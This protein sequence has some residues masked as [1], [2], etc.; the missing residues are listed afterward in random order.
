MTVGLIDSLKLKLLE[1]LFGPIW[2]PMLFVIPCILIGLVI[3]KNMIDP[4]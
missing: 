3:Q 4:S 1:V 2:L